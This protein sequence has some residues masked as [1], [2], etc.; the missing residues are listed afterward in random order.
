[1]LLTVF[2]VCS[3]CRLTDHKSHEADNISAALDTRRRDLSVHIQRLENVE[4]KATEVLKSL[5]KHHQM[6]LDS[7]T[8]IKNKIRDLSTET[9]TDQ[10]KLGLRILIHMTTYSLR[11]CDGML[12]NQ[13][14]NLD[15][16][17]I[18]ERKAIQATRT[19]TFEE[20]DEIEEEML[21]GR[22][23]KDDLIKLVMDQ[24]RI[25]QMPYPRWRDR[26]HA[27]T[28][29]RNAQNDISAS[30]TLLKQDLEFKIKQPPSTGKRTPFRRSP[31]ER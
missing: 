9:N 11:E 6:I 18:L 31:P 29:T 28:E 22:G 21:T 5:Q 26:T 12:A 3:E 8:D 19:G 30:I 24:E 14:K 27:Q 4:T 16:I 15:L 2:Q 25:N 20:I 10:R 17:Q 13:E 23:N 1:M 7:D